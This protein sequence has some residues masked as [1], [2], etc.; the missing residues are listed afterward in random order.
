MFGNFI[1]NFFY[2]FNDSEFEGGCEF[3]CDFLSNIY[4]RLYLPEN[5]IVCIGENFSELIMIQES[6]V[7][8]MVMQRPRKYIDP[9]ANDNDF[10]SPGQEPQL[11]E[12]FILPTYSYFGDYQILYDLK[13]QITYKAGDGNLNKLCITLC[14]KK[15]KLLEMME[16]YPE[17]R[18]FYMER[19][20]QRRIEFR[21]RMKKFH[22][23]FEKLEYK[24]GDKKLFDT[25][26]E[27]S[28]ESEDDDSLIEDLEVDRNAKKRAMQLEKLI[29][30][31]ISKFY[32][33][34][35]DEELENDID[36][37]DLEELSEEE[38]QLPEDTM[39]IL[40][41]DNKKISQE[42]AKNIQAQMQ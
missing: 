34:D 31:N 36:T 1:T 28:H 27:D 3:T 18:K 35:K 15:N 41:E 42:H 19:S 23:Q 38:K 32:P 26:N 22:E 40:N 13:S 17:A 7:S 39:E 5:E 37:E 6:V 29:N 2:L 33:I 20:W 25:N 21:R 14:L 12:F 9:D 4:S 30:N 24:N 10:F 16:D 11:V 8:L